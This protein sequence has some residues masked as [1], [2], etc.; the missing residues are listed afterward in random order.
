MFYWTHEGMLLCIVVCTLS[1]STVFFKASSL[2]LRNEMNNVTALSLAFM[3]ET[4][5]YTHIL[6]GYVV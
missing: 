6:T 2:W 5:L 4:H 3:S 1:A